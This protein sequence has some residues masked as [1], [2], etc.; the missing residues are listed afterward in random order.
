MRIK[1]RATGLH[2]DGMGRTADGAAAAQY[3]HSTSNNQQWSVVTDAGNVR[4]RNRATGL[5]LDGMGRT[6]AG[7]EL[8][9]YSDTSSGNQRW[10]I[11]A[12]G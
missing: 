12:V 8:A 3:A 6:T 2:L 11:V 1:N 5:Y 10:K 4:I 7:A 9:Q